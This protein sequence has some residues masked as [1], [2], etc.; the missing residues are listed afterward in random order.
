MSATEIIQELPK[1]T[2]E[3]LSAVRH[4]LRELD[5]QDELQFLHESAVLTFQDL[6]KKEAEADAV[7]AEFCGENARAQLRFA[8]MSETVA[9][10]KGEFA[11][12]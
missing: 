12:W 5:E 8:L 7:R 4:R 9:H 2:S 6:D 10:A 3:E 11:E 1:L